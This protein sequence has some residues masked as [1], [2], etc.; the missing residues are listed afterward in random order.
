MLEK[1]PHISRTPVL[2]HIEPPDL[3]NLTKVKQPER[4]FIRAIPVC[5]LK[6][7]SGELT[8]LSLIKISNTPEVLQ[9]RSTNCAQ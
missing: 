5:H 7:D 3:I 4:H 9:V 8:S 6:Y 2:A 1:L